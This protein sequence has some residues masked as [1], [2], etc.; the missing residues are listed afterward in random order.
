MTLEER[1][2]RGAAGFGQGEDV[3]TRFSCADCAA[4]L[5]LIRAAEPFAEYAA[6]SDDLQAAAGWALPPDQIEICVA[7][8]DHEK[9]AS[10][11]MGQARVIMAALAAVKSSDRPEVQKEG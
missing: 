11:T 10:C 3:T 2:E 8:Q 9:V 4:L 7:V 6:K 1:L 5:A